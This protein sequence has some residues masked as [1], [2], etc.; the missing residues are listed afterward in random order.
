MASSFTREQ[1]IQV[2]F[3]IRAK[4]MSHR[5]ASLS[6]NKAR[7]PQQSSES[8]CYILQQRIRIDAAVRSDEIAFLGSPE[9]AD[10]RRIF[11]FVNDAKSPCKPV[12]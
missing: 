6:I 9:R 10:F 2:F 4:E 12:S 1:T 3:F 8:Q 11:R 5:H 7:Y